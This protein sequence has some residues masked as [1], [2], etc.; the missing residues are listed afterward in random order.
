MGRKQRKQHR[1][2][3]TA[4]LAMLVVSQ[5]FLNQ[6]TFAD[7]EPKASGPIVATDVV[8]HKETKGFDIR[9]TSPFVQ[10]TDKQLEAANTL[11]QRVGSG[12]KINWNSTFGT[13]STI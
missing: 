12:L 9:E 5:L 1:K 6:P 8:G 2:A 4:T 11:I 7:D 10:P 3:A 13:P